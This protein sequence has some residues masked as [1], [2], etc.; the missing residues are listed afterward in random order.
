MLLGGL[1][2]REEFDSIALAIGSM[3]PFVSREVESL[4]PIYV[5]PE[6]A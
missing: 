5:E 4:A 3:A 1:G 2:W 6:F